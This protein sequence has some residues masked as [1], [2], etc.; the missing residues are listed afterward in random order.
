MTNL[1]EEPISSSSDLLEL[2]QYLDRLTGKPF[3]FA[4]FS[5]G[6]ELTLHFG[7]VRIEKL[8][9]LVSLPYGEFML[10]ARASEVRRAKFDPAVRRLHFAEM[11]TAWSP[12]LTRADVESSPIFSSDCFVISALAFRV[13]PDVGFGFQLVMSSGEA[14]AILPDTSPDAEDEADDGLPDIADWEI[15]MPGGYLSAGPGL[16]WSFEKL[17]TSDDN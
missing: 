1:V 17:P 11:P 9:K 6:D 14:V 10:G 16:R 5:Y 13:E 7:D 2:A 15:F 8:T 12:P 3:Q 4:R